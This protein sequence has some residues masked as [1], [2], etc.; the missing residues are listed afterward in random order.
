MSAVL[1]LSPDCLTN[2]T[3]LHV[4]EVEGMMLWPNDP[5]ARQ[6]WWN[7]A[8]L[9]FGAA[10][11][12]TMP[13]WMV[14]PFARMALASPRIAELRSQIEKKGTIN[15]GILLGLRVLSAINY[16]TTDHAALDKIDRELCAAFLAKGFP[17]APR[18]INNKTGPIYPLRPAAH[19]WAAWVHREYLVAGPQAPFPCAVEKLAEFL[20]V[21]DAIRRLAETTRAPKAKATVM[22][23]GEAIYLPDEVLAELP[24]LKMERS[25]EISR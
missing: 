24:K 15:H 18:T 12:D 20:A 2:P 16:A 11:L 13:A 19:L 17:I 25:T 9:E 6:V 10:G 14:R 23:P 8:F 7:A 3:L 4:A 1:E 5:V 22:H 21:A